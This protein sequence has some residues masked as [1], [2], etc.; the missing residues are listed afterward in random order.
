MAINPKIL[1]KIKKWTNPPYDQ[2]C[3]DEIKSLL[4]KGDEKELIERFGAELDFGT[5]GIRGIIGYGT[6][7]MNIYTI[8]QATQGL[9]NYILK[10]NIKE[11]KAVIAYDSRLYSKEFA[12]KTATILASNGIKTYLF[13]ELRPTPE[14]SYA[15][16][17]LKCTTG[18]VIT[19]SHNP[20]NY[21]GY[22]VY[23]DDGAQITSPQDDGIIEEARKI[24]E[25][26]Q[27]KDHVI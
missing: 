25:L 19:A 24:K 26:N 8:A 21:N 11:P 20:K 5:G 12:T 9:A 7:R 1:L 23:W 22:K 6:N 18:I 27:V 3:I 13:K 14:L 16:R 2:N 4:S 17:Y 15:I 10:N